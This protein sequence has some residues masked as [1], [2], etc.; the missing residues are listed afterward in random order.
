MDKVNILDVDIDNVNFEDAIAKIC[1]FVEGGDPKFVVTPNVDHVIKL[2]RDLEFKQIYKEASLVLA[3][4]APIIWA[5]KLLKTPLK[6]KISGSDLFPRLCE[7]SSNEGFKLFF[8]GGRQGAAKGAADI[9]QAKYPNIKISGI[10]SPPF[11]FEDDENENIRIVNMIKEA[12]PDILFVGLGA[13]KQEKWIYKYYTELN[14]PVSIGVGVSFEFMA[15]IVKR[16]PLWMQK[17]GLEWF[18]RLMM[19]P[20]KL[21]K[22]YLVDDMKIFWLILRQKI[23]Q[24]SQDS[25]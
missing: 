10:Y 6:E 25:R 24:V 21:W 1:E 22:R 15:G 19:E 2:Q 18:W 20:K 7:V 14:V 17:V 11:G 3:D 5:A 4:G 16:A 13:P 12:R 8:L 9:F 23:Y